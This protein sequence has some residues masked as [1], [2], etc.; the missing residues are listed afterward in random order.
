VDGVD[1]VDVSGAM[2]QLSGLTA[3]LEADGYGLVVEPVE[4]GIRVQVVAGSEACA[5]CLAPERLVRDLI[6][7][8]LAGRVSLVEL[9]Y[10]S[11]AGNLE[12]G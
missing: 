3:M 5:D 4:G 11:S 2:Q 1:G 7:E 9:R 8:K 6:E 10:P 12:C